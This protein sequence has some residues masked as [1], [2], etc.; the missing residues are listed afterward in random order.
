MSDQQ[1][2]PRTL[3]I[4]LIIFFHSTATTLDDNIAKAEISDMIDNG[5]AI[6]LSNLSVEQLSEYGV[7]SK[8]D[9]SEFFDEATIAYIENKPPPILYDEAMA[10]YRQKLKRFEELEK[11]MAE[12]GITYPYEMHRRLA[13]RS[14]LRYISISDMIIDSHPASNILENFDRYQSGTEFGD[15]FGNLSEIA[16][17]SYYRHTAKFL[18]ELDDPFES[19]K[20]TRTNF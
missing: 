10:T 1:R 5:D 17:S 19:L 15:K 3:S 20:N 2:K 7:R 18:D 16:M 6:A 11:Y 9:L 4:L 13:E 14:D 8:N 12:S